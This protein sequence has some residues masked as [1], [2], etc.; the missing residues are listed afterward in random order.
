MKRLQHEKRV[1]PIRAVHAPASRIPS[2]SPELLFLQ[3]EGGICSHQITPSNVR[4]T[5]ELFSFSFFFFLNKLNIS[6]QEEGMGFRLV[7]L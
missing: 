6:I 7:S 1:I 4:M 3:G 5:N 2:L